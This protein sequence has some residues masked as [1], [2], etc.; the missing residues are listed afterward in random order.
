[1]TSCPDQAQTLA[2]LTAFAKGETKIRGIGSLRVKETERVIAIERELKKMG[3]AT[4]S[5]KDTLTIYGGKPHSAVIETYGD[6][7]MAMSFAVAG[8]VLSGMEICEPEVVNKTFP[9]FWE[10]LKQVGVGV[11]SVGRRL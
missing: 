2:V 4:Q 9:E 3:I 1:M 11:L 8:S 10:K 6:H 7:R 5:T